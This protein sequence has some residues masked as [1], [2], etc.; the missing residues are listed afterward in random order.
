MEFCNRL[1]DTETNFSW[2]YVRLSNGFVES[3]LTVNSFTQGAFEMLLLLKV[4][5]I[6]N[7]FTHMFIFSLPLT[8]KLTGPQLVK[9]F[10]FREH[11][12]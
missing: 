6:P 8:E 10:Y 1:L 11:K 5:I 4:V 3:N 9:K 2:S 7:D 12:G